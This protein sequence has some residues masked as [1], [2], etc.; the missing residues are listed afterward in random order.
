MPTNEEI[1]LSKIL[2][3]IIKTNAYLAQLTQNGTY[4]ISD[5]YSKLDDVV[6]SVDGVGVD[7][8]NISLK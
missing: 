4:G 7:I 2:E 5:V 1:T 6:S 3:E 8:N